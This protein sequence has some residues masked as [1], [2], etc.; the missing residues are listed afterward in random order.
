MNLLQVLSISGWFTLVALLILG[1]KSIFFNWAL[2][3]FRPDLSIHEKNFKKLSV[4]R[5]SSLYAAVNCC[6]P[7][8]D[9]KYSYKKNANFWNIYIVLTKCNAYRHLCGIAVI[10]LLSGKTWNRCCLSERWRPPHPPPP[11]SLPP[12]PPPAN[13]PHQTYVTSFGKG[14]SEKSP[15]LDEGTIFA[16][17][18]AI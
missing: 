3:L 12:P 1:G 15:F 13:D 2:L 9:Q 14:W 17:D 16:C 5:N 6:L 8:W 10:F 7:V 18:T 4:L 11:L